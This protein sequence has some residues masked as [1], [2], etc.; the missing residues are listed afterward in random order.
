MTHRILNEYQEHRA[1]AV[2][3]IT[4]QEEAIKLLATLKEGDTLEFGFW[5]FKGR[6]FINIA[7]TATV[8]EK[9]IRWYFYTDNVEV[10]WPLYGIAHVLSYLKIGDV[11]MIAKQEETK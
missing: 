10:N 7:Y 6:G 3:S 8:V 11:E 9:H 4:Q 1:G 2:F 5:N